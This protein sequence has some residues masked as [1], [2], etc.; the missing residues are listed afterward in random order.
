LFVSF[1]AA[2]YQQLSVETASPPERGI[3]GQPRFS[4]A[5]SE[6]LIGLPAGFN[7]GGRTNLSQH[8]QA[9]T[10]CYG[11]T[12]VAAMPLDSYSASNSQFIAIRQELVAS[13][14]RLVEY[15]RTEVSE[16]ARPAD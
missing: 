13:R 6:W 3:R 11:T 2:G 15:Y 5:L 9:A 8:A 4:P 16:G 12:P 10:A 1:P 14:L 7:T